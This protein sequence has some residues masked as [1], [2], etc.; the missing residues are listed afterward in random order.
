MKRGTVSMR[1]ALVLRSAEVQPLFRDLCIRFALASGL[2]CRFSPLLPPPPFPSPLLDLG[3]GGSPPSPIV[4]CLWRSLPSLGWGAWGGHMVAS[5][6]V[7]PGYLY[8]GHLTINLYRLG[9]FFSVSWWDLLDLVKFLTELIFSTWRNFF[10]LCLA[11]GW[12]R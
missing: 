8:P 10:A 9:G 5:R 2:E 3:S 12:L 6:F 1:V 4:G 11:V 7:H